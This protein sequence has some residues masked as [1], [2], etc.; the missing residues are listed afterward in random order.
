MLSDAS[1]EDK[2]VARKWLKQ[3]SY[4]TKGLVKLAVLIAF[5]SVLL[6]IGQ[7]YLL[8]HISYD[9]YLQNSTQSQ[10]SIYFVLI[11]LSLN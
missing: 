4:P 5:L 3:I 10:L 6:L 1:K 2:K 7:L 9:A 8:A 11:I